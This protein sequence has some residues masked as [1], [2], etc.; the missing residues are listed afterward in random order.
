MKFVALVFLFLTPFVSAAADE[1]PAYEMPRTEVL[2]FRDAKAD[3]QYELYV[4]LPEDYAENTD[5]HYPVIYT[6]DA[7]WHMEMLSG[8]TEYLMPNVILVGIS[9]QTDLGLEEAF[10]SRFRDYTVVEYK[11]RD[12]QA[13]YQG[14][15]AS[16]HLVF[17]KDG[18]IPYVESKYRADPAQRTY[19][20]YSLGGAFGAYVLLAAPDTFKNYVLGSPAIGQ[21]TLDYFDDLEATRAT[22]RGALNAHAFVS[23]GELEERRLEVT[24]N[25]LSI[26]QRRA[27]AGLTITGLEKI[28]DA[29]HGAAFPETT[30]R[31][32]KWLQ[33]M[34][35]E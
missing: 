11:D 34:Q 9:W 6:T 28:E 14:G 20:G 29:D 24:Q 23:I 31:S 19:F 2:P 18:V 10:A 25:L 17:I 5:T 26:L 27:A 32:I 4:K 16:K 7:V 21:S 22:Q 8:A 3:R 30:I 12:D 33:E 13:Q 1:P 15:Q 35:E